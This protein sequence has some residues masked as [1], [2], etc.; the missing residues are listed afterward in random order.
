MIAR[1][2]R[3]GRSGGRV[4]GV[5]RAG[6]K[7]CGDGLSRGRRTVRFRAQA[8]CCRGDAT[9]DAAACKAERVREPAAAAEAADENLTPI[10]AVVLFD[11]LQ[12]RIEVRQVGVLAT[13]SWKQAPPPCGHT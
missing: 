2:V 10:D 7:Q 3:P 8:A 4:V 9:D 6:Q 5:V 1:G 12:D 11:L 13:P